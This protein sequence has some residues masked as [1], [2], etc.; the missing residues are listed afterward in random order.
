MSKKL[1]DY[2]ALET[3]I[4]GDGDLVFLNTTCRIYGDDGKAQQWDYLDSE[5]DAPLIGLDTN[6]YLRCNVGLY[7]LALTLKGI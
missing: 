5:G 4:D 3:T 6:V 2:L 1:L 7:F